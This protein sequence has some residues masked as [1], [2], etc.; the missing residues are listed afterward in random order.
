MDAR[1][2]CG[3]RGFMAGGGAVF[4]VGLAGCARGFCAE[5]GVPAGA[6]YAPWRDW[7]GSAAEGPLRLL[8]AAILA[9]NAHDTQP[10]LF[11]LGGGRI[12][13]YADERR[14]LGAMDPFRREMRLSIGCAIENLAIAAA[15]DGYAVRL[16]AVPGSLLDRSPDPGPRLAARILL[17]PAPAPAQP[18]PE[19]AAIPLRH[20]N[21]GAYDPERP[22]ASDF[23][24]GLA[25]L[26]DPAAGTAVAIL[27]D[28]AMRRDFAAATLAATQAIIDDAPMI[29]DSDA[30]FRATDAEIEAHRDGPTIDAAGLSPLM[31][32]L[33][34]LLPA[35]S[36]ERAHRFWYEHTR[37]VALATAPVFG[38]ITVRDLYDA[39][40]AIAA[41]RLWQRLHLRA[42]LAGVAAQPLNQLPERIDRDRQL[43][44]P[45]VFAPALARLAG[46]RNGPATFAFRLGWPV[47]EAPPSPRRALAD[48]LVP[49]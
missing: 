19:F 40:Q 29:R 39:G 1:M 45:P 37:D 14:N 2:I 32:T 31:R 33:A 47:R 6:A 3:R 48:T 41:G 25:A 12:D 4:A 5:D 28:P 42:T 7:R 15:A 11:A 27:G 23:L 24:A 9:A 17:A 22:L 20:T 13:I 44:R 34:K 18:P 43:G 8:R 16:E 38:L 26:A 21:R 46:D 49:A 30:W 10:W 35:P 36:P